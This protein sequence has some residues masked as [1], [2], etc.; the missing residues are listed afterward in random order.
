[1]FQDLS[2]NRLLQWWTVKL[3]KPHIYLQGILIWDLMEK[4]EDI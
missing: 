4:E 1:M 3:L 2:V